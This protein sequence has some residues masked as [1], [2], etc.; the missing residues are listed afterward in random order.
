MSSNPNVEISM[1]YEGMARA[2]NAY[3]RAA[4]AY[5]K[6]IQQL[7]AVS[8]TLS[9]EAILGDTG[10]AAE[11]YVNHLVSQYGEMRRRAT[12]MRKDIMDNVNKFRGEVDPGIAS[13][14]E[15]I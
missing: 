8:D 11:N 10:N 2:A 13:M 15:A 9:K 14:F 4:S 5:S 12:E 1:D 7:R 6:I 3:A